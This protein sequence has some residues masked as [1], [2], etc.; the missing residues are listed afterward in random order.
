MQFDS[1]SSCDENSIFKGISQCESAKYANILQK[2]ILK[3]QT[4]TR[5]TPT[6]QPGPDPTKIEPFKFKNI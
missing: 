5:C 4:R 1:I 6:H 3:M 2:C